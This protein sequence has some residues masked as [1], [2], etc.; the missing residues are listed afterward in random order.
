[1]KKKI[2]LLAIGLFL[3]VLSPIVYAQALSFVN[4]QIEFIL[5]N[6]IIIA[7]VLFIV[8]AIMLKD[9][10]AEQKGFVWIMIILI[11]VVISY[12]YR[13]EF[14]W[15]VI[16][17]D[18][19]FFTLRVIVNT[20]VLSAFFYFLLQFTPGGKLESKPGQTGAIIL[21]LIL[22]AVISGSVTYDDDGNQR[23]IWN[24]DT[25]K[26]FRTYLFGD[27][28][29]LTMNDNR[30]FIFTG[31]V[32]V[33]AWLFTMFIKPEGGVGNKLNYALALIIASEMASS[34]P[35]ASA[36]TLIWIGEIVTAIALY[37]GLQASFSGL[38]KGWGVG[39]PLVI[40]GALTHVVATI[41]FKEKAL[42]GGQP[43]AETAADGTV[44]FPIGKIIWFVVGIAIVIFIIV[45]IY[46]SE[47][48]FGKYSRGILTD[49]LKHAA[50][51]YKRFLRT[52]GIPGL[53]LIT[54]HTKL[55]D[56]TPVGEVP[57]ILRDL[58][59]EL[60]VLM[61][62]MLRLEVF[63]GKESAVK[64]FVDSANSVQDVFRE[65]PPDKV[66]QR[67]IA[68]KVG[69]DLTIEENEF[70]VKFSESS[71]I[72]KED[73]VP[74]WLNTPFII[75]K[76]MNELIK[77]LST[78]DLTAE[79]Q[80]VAP[81]AESQTKI[82]SGGRDVAGSFANTA[83]PLEHTSWI[84]FW[85]HMR[86]AGAIHL[87]TSLRQEMIDQ[88]RLYGDYVHN[89]VFAKPDAEY[90]LYKW[91]VKKNSDGTPMWDGVVRKVKTTTVEQHIGNRIGFESGDMP[92]E[93]DASGYVLKDKN[94]IEVELKDIYIRKVKL[95]DIFEFH[96][97][98]KICGWLNLEW[99]YFI[100][101]MRD[102]RFHP[103]SRSSKDYNTL[104][105]KKIFNYSNLKSASKPGKNRP[106]FD[107]EAMKNPGNASY[108]GRKHYFEE[109]E[110][111]VGISRV[112]PYPKLST[113]GI[114][115]YIGDLVEKTVKEI[116]IKED[117]LRRYVYETAKDAKIGD[118]GKVTDAE[119]FAKIP[120]KEAPQ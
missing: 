70:K 101:D 81:A 13:S 67:I 96:P 54:R 99:K 66:K 89:Y 34:T 16:D 59:V 93:V 85:G 31:A 29:I 23:F 118:D 55:R 47:G 27:T 105:A 86:R 22:S 95:K 87:L 30:L 32:V 33:F 74:G 72:P 68:Y 90:D 49:G 88:Y 7:L 2:L 73:Q 53:N 11:S 44:G 10:K 42:F 43:I 61:N 75:G 52:T 104:H 45:K 36:T 76:L 91:E 111:L 39:V 57:F 106:A 1:M 102:G 108:W 120:K 116:S 107:R 94:E 64:N 28:G 14:I 100:F 6:T 92:Y 20:I 109:E 58:R 48:K 80:N 79:V 25:I 56:S 60:E 115:E 9:I 15:K 19:K 113:I 5:V 24:T 51:K 26:T 82:F 62:Y 103:T 65:I 50:S 69:P 114:S 4:T 83:Q 110:R 63:S 21:I 40:S 112:N 117:H 84:Y 18:G 46:N 12:I 78:A 98:Y 35:P 41:V 97:Y 3:L 8:Q 119:Y 17:A 38:G 71:D 37:K 77:K